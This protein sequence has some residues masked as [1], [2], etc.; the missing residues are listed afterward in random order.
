VSQEER[1]IFWEVIASAILKK[2]VYVNMSPILKGF[3]LARNI[4]LPSHHYVPLSEACELVWRVSWLLWLLLSGPVILDHITGQNYLEFLQH[5]LPEQLE[6][7][8][9]ATRIA[10]YFQHDGAHPHY[11]RLM[12]QHLNDTFPNQWIS[13]GSTIKWPPRSPDLPH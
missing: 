13:R 9:L 1:S 8:P 5:E 4:F 6:N 7:V 12:M 2:K 3:Y 11:T 10:M